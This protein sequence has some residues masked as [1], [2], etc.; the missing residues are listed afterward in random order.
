MRAWLACRPIFWITLLGAM[1]RLL[2]VQSP[3]I[4]CDEALTYGRS[5]GTYR[6]LILAL[7]DTAFAPLHYQAIW[8]IGH[9]F[10]LTP[11]VLRLIAI[12][13]GILTV[14]A[15]Y[16]LARQLVTRKVA[17]LVALFTACSA[18]MLVYS[19]DAKMYPEFWFCCIV[20]MGFFICWLR[21]GGFTGYL[22][23]LAASVAMVGLDAL[24][25]IVLALAPIL[26]IS[27]KKPSWKKAVWT[28][29]GMVIVSAGP[30]IYYNHFNRLV[31][32]T[33]DE[34][35][36]QGTGTFWVGWY[37]QGR[38]G[39]DHLLYM[40]S[41]YLFSWE[42]PRVHDATGMEPPQ[43][44]S[45]VDPQVL[46]WLKVSAV[47]FLA[48]GAVGLLPW[49]SRHGGAR[50]LRGGWRTVLWL[51]VWM[52]VPVYGFFCRSV[53]PFP[54]PL[55]IGGYFGGHW[56][57]MVACILASAAIL[58][59]L[60]PRYGKWIATIAMLG[61]LLIWNVLLLPRN[62]QMDDHI[63]SSGLLIFGGAALA[64]GHNRWIGRLRMAGRIAIILAVVMGFCL[65]IYRI[66]P[67]DPVGSIWIPRYMAVIW[68]AFA[69]VFCWAITRIP[70]R[71]VRLAVVG[72]LLAVNL[73]RFIN[74]VCLSVNMDAR[75][76]WIV[77]G[78]EPPFDLIAKDVVDSDTPRQDTIGKRTVIWHPRSDTRTYVMSEPLG[79]G[80][81]GTGAIWSWPGKYYLAIL[82]GI[83]PPA[84]NDFHSPLPRNVFSINQNVRP[85][86][87]ARD[88]ARSKQIQRVIVWDVLEPEGWS[89]PD[90]LIRQLGT[91][92][93]FISQMVFPVQMHW[94]GTQTKTLRRREYVRRP[95]AILTA[96]ATQP[97]TRP[98]SRP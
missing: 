54:S 91:K 77:E 72:L 85:M 57:A 34:N 68:P 2:F 62:A 73:Q 59:G 45:L 52:I 51:S 19:R 47:V 18:Y 64:V 8:V 40:S 17:N 56:V 76:N 44:E 14:P 96:P 97:T 16:F 20:S 32:K 60:W 4:W 95:P 89:Q 58:A 78:T 86:G 63:V 67:A 6:Q 25:F 84:D 5:S 12:L 9:Y 26:Q 37:N 10:W 15:I 13:S 1:L 43:D 31:T 75:G 61:L 11:P 36:T 92:W 48:A 28:L 70:I 81:P 87:I 22:V 94:L 3:A 29:A 27:A 50:V 98:A 42:W 33:Q 93:D 83:T 80:H 66:S 79:I 21:R 74:R 65:I 38:T 90:M 49:R 55:D 88:L 24:G 82:S 23:W 7:R 39:F 53:Q 71:A 69:V 41:S 35:L 30:T 46:F